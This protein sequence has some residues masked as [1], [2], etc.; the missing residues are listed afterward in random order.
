MG[1]QRERVQKGIGYI[2]RHWRKTCALLLVLL[3]GCSRTKHDGRFV[4][5]EDRARQALEAGLAAWRRG[6]PH[7]VV[8]GTTPGV[9][10]IDSHH[11]PEQRLDE[12]SI[13]SLAPGDGP[14]EFTVKLTLTS[15]PQELKVRYIVVGIDPI[16]VV[17]NEDY[18]MITHW[19][20]PMAKP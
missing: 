2:M 12:F 5:P 13:L 16:W 14:R 7:G 9:H 3:A 20:E 11:K 10:F 1:L 6:E 17:R 15:P 18:E 19:C 4:P 8:A